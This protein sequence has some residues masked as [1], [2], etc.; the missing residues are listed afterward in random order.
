MKRI[1]VH[2]LVKPNTFHIWT[3][4]SYRPEGNAAC[5]YLI[6]S[7]A[8]Q[9]VVHKS[10]YASRGSTIN[11]ME[12]K[13]I[14]LSLEYP[15]LENVIIY[16]DSAYSIQCLTIWR[17]SWVQRNWMDMHGNPV[18]NRELIESIGKQVDA[19]PNVKFVKCSAHSGDYFNSAVDAMASDLTKR[20]TTDKS[21]MI[22]E[23][24][25]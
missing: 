5:A 12:L 24:P 9:K 15:G 14:G 22:G 11:Q 4:G 25:I 2:K 19:I 21:I 13:S 7:E 3:D 6:F 23:Y 18:K 17:R 10:S 20:M 1:D 8:E 16:S